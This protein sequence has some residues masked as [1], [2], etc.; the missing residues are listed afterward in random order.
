VETKPQVHRGVAEQRR[1]DPYDEGRS[2]REEKGGSL[3][4]MRVEEGMVKEELE[5]MKQ[6]VGRHV[7]HEC[8]HAQQ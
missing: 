6:A 2:Q 4:W 1:E 7:Q 3:K 5:K 8:Q